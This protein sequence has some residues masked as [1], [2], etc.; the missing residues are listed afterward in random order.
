MLRPI[1]LRFICC[2]S[3][4]CLGITFGDLRGVYAASVKDFGAVGDGRT[5]DTAAL[6]KAVASAA[7]ELEFPAGVYRIQKTIRI[8]LDK[9]GFASLTGRGGASLVMAGSGPAIE[10]IGTH[11]GTADPKSVQDNVWSRQRMPRV[12]GL[13]IVGDNASADGIQADGTMQ[14]SIDGVLI[15]KCRHAIRLTGRNR[16]LLVSNCHLYENRGCGIL[17]DAVN[18]HQSNIVGCHIS[19]CNEGGVVIRGG[20]VR[21][22][23]I[24]TCDLE[25]NMT[26]DG[27]AAANVLIDCQDGSTDEVAITGCTL[28]HN[29]HSP[30]SANIRVLGRGITSAKNNTPTQ[31]GHITITGNVMSDVMV[32][33]HLVEA[34]GVT[35]TGNTFWEG[36]EHDILM[37]SCQA[38]VVGPNDL[39]R[40]PRYVVN[41][42]WSEDRGGIV[43]RVLGFQSSTVFSSKAFGKSRQPSSSSI[44]DA[45]RSTI[46]AFLIAMDMVWNCETASVARSAT[47]L[48]TTNAREKTDAPKDHC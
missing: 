33:V 45:S 37:E 26:T 48:L 47:A 25:S 15:R 23:H 27:P 6:E 10:F 17:Y 31:E 14:L 20:E 39:D 5:D 8:D 30:G 24:G 2:L 40:N 36:F 13:E 43:M 21:N 46:S 22:V 32:N 7:V 28:Q 38:V 29:S 11:A 19:Y 16:N 34:R 3:L 9:V 1:C 41:G 35:I 12:Q 4:A 18:L 44:A 42:H